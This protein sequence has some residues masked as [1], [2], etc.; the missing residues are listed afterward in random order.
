MAIVRDRVIPPLPTT[1]RGKGIHLDGTIHKA[2]RILYCANNI[3]IGRFLDDEKEVFINPDSHAVKATVARFSRNGE[4]I[5]S[6]DESGKGDVYA[7]KMDPNTASIVS[8][9]CEKTGKK[10]NA[11]S[12]I[13]DIAWDDRKVPNKSMKIAIVGRGK[14]EK[15]KII[16][17]ME[18]SK[19]EVQI[20]PQ[21]DVL[22]ADFK[23]CPDGKLKLVVGGEDFGIYLYQRAGGAKTWGKNPFEFVTRI[24]CHTNY[25]NSIKF[26]PD[27]KHFVSVSSDKKIVVFDSETGKE[28]KT[29][30][31]GKGKD[32]HKGTIYE[33][34]FS[35]DGSRFVT[36]SADK[37]CKVWNFESG[38]VEFTYSFADKPTKNEMQVSCLWLDEKT[39]F[40]VSL[41]GRINYLDPEFKE[42]RPIKILSGHMKSIQDV[43][44]NAKTNSIYTCDS[45]SC[46]VRTNCDSFV[47][48]DVKGDPHG[49]T[50]I[51]YIATTCDNSAF[52]TVA[53]NDT[54]CKTLVADQDEE[55][56]GGMNA[57]RFGEKTVK[58]DGAA[59]GFAAGN[60]DANLLVVPIHR[61][62]LVFINDLTVSKQVDVPY[63]PTTC[64][65]AKDDSILAVGSGRDGENAV[66]IYDVAN[67][68]KPSCVINN[69]QYLRN[70][71]VSIALTDDNAFL[72]TADKDRNIWIWDLKS[73]NFE[74]PH[75]FNRSMK[76]H[77]GQIRHIE[78]GGKD[79]KQ[80]LT[81]ANDST[82][83]LF[84]DPTQSAEYIKLPQAFI[85]VI[86]KAIFISPTT[87]AGVGGDNTIRFFKIE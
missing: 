62:K 53:V 50:Q 9:Y 42:Q 79:G 67:P 69:K 66:Y 8:Q 77:V 16:D 24:K 46:V 6:G 17:A 51:K 7:D 37:T 68:E 21:K 78:F 3:V 31:D 15:V 32:Q 29:I 2:R 20:G 4:Y 58:L 48:A 54:V 49:E 10:L 43:T 52:Y 64:T 27:G 59:R 72:A 70:D 23:D 60:K 1:E 39:I 30:A 47:T 84:A 45:N 82:L 35:P 34:S 36:A 28:V 65:L 86:K 76:Y 11:T 83:F 12:G 33:V 61:K 25:V 13:W 87:I 80:L 57:G 5:A 41:S 55:K 38:Q 26:S 63:T 14:E 71:I 40:S 85:G 18:G 56:G 81:C 22:C 74:K 44:Y 73:K 75:N 19:P